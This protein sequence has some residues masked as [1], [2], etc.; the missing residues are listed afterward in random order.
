MFQ[1]NRISLGHN[2][3]IIMQLITPRLVCYDAVL[4]QMDY[5]K[6]VMVLCQLL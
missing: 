1:E 2:E 3:F 5:A 4:Q 6:L